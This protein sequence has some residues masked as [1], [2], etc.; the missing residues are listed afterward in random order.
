M[1]YVFNCCRAQVN[2][3]LFYAMYVCMYDVSILWIKKMDLNENCAQDNDHL[4]K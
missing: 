3:N 1:L 4:Y 2:I